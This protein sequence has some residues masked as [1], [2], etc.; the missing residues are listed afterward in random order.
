VCGKSSITDI[1]PI[2]VFFFPTSHLAI[3]FSR[4]DQ[5]ERN[6][7]RAAS[8]TP[9]GS[10][11]EGRVRELNLLEK[12]ERKREEQH[13]Y[14]Q[15]MAMNPI[16]VETVPDDIPEIIEEVEARD[17]VE[18]SVRS[19]TPTVR[20]IM[21]KREQQEKLEAEY[22]ATLLKRREEEM[23]LMEET[24]RIVALE[25]EY[26]VGS[27]RTTDVMQR[28]LLMDQHRNRL[29]SKAQLDEDV[30][31]LEQMRLVEE[32]EH[33]RMTE[34]RRAEDEAEMIK[35]LEEEAAAKKKEAEEAEERAKKALEEVEKT[36]KDLIA[37]TIAIAE[38]E[39]VAEAEECLKREIEEYKEPTLLP[40]ASEVE[41]E[42]WETLRSE[43]RSVMTRRVMAGWTILA[44]FCNGKECENCPLITKNGKKECCV[45]GGCGDGTDGAYARGSSMDSEEEANG[46]EHFILAKKT[47]A[48]SIMS[49]APSFVSNPAV[50]QT[51]QTD[52]EARRKAVSQEMNKKVTE[53]WTLLDSSC[54]A[55]VMP[56]MTDEKGLEDVCVFCDMHGIP[57]NQRKAHYVPSLPTFVAPPVH[58]ITSP[59]SRFTADPPANVPSYD[60]SEAE[61][62]ISIPKN[63]DFS[64]QN[65]IVNLI[66][67]AAGKGNRVPADPL[68]GNGHQIPNDEIIDLSSYPSLDEQDERSDMIAMMFM[69]SSFGAQY[70]SPNG[71]IDMDELI[72]SVEI[73]VKLNF[74]PALEDMTPDIARAVWRKIRSL[75]ASN[76]AEA[77]VSRTPR[78]EGPPKPE[79]RPGT[80]RRSQPNTPKDDN[81]FGFSEISGDD[82]SISDK[83]TKKLEDIL[84]KIEHCKE[85]LRHEADVE[86]QM[87]A[88]NLIEQLSKAA[89]AVQGGGEDDV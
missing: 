67:R 65:A 33:R 9:T 73:Y 82:F 11:D 6:I 74:G 23:I 29:A 77:Y 71:Q 78:S 46:P 80:P 72:D 36:R 30:L 2:Q 12:L 83:S 86:K 81:V 88:A 64:D 66:N 35:Q 54:P 43:G 18:Q 27:I 10:Y 20:D 69:E 42:Q 22:R 85:A 79:S 51:L 60:E 49:S 75:P 48:P 50:M 58:S 53:G 37:Q 15:R 40:T 4:D 31:K 3:F 41:A 44:E 61:M 70:Q 26:T 56:L 47:A 13:L 52:F 5:P 62:T 59:T 76:V 28:D 24:K 38:A 45:C 63:F 39:V 68:P 19:H 89:L 17:D 87:E 8:S 7:N 57:M 32:M 1:H 55:C 21:F 14:E 16:Q 84:S 34:E 25:E